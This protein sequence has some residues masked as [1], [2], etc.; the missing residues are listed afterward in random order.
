MHRR[1]RRLF[2]FLD[3][4]QESRDWEIELKNAYDLEALK[5]FCTGS[6]SALIKEQGGRAENAVSMELQRKKISCG[7]FAESEREVDF[8]IGAAKDPHPVEVKY[9]S[10]FDWSERRFAGIKLFLRRYPAT[11]KVLLI[12]RNVE[13]RIKEHKTDIILVPLWRFLLSCDTYLEELG[14]EAPQ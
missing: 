1:E 9:L 3:E 7:Y 4:V 14:G 2:L 8:I 13:K 5:V 12:T 6:T 11:R 10:S